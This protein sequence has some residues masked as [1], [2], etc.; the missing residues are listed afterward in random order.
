MY[1]GSGFAKNIKRKRVLR[2]TVLFCF[3]CWDCLLVVLFSLAIANYSD[4]IWWWKS[5]KKYI[6]WCLDQLIKE[7]LL[8]N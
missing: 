6:C 3:V 7:I 8:F 5:S 2:V 1:T 4:P